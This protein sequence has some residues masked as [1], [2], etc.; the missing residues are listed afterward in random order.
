[1]Q[2]VKDILKSFDPLEDKY[3][4]REYQSY[5]IYLAEKL[6]D[7]R[8]KSMYIKFAKTIPR[9]VLAEALRFVIDSN[10]KRKAALFMWKLKEI[11]AFKSR[12]KAKK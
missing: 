1:M 3:I 7:E 4:S 2:T 12:R 11:G 8:H 6:Q 9:P 10:A 5:G